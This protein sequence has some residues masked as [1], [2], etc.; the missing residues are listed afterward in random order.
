MTASRRRWRRFDIV[1]P[2]E[3]T[4]TRSTRSTATSNLCHGGALVQVGDDAERGAAVHLRIDLPDQPS[5][6]ATGLVRHIDASNRAGVEFVV[7]PVRH[8]EV[9]GAWLEAWA[10]HNQPERRSAS[11]RLHDLVVWASNGDGLH[12]YALRDVSRT[13]MFLHT[14]RDFSVGDAISTMLVDPHSEHTLALDARVV[15]VTRGGPID[16][17]GVGVAFEGLAPEDERRLIQL[18]G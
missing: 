17:Q 1:L 15:R 18:L 3:V 13:G 9:F 11:R 7:V 8:R 16:R 6:E 14:T 10:A 5:L 2:G 4:T 12:G